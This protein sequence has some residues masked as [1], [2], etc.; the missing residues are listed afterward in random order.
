MCNSFRIK[1]FVWF[2]SNFFF[3]R[4][5]CLKRESYKPREKPIIIFS[6]SSCRKGYLSIAYPCFFYFIEKNKCVSHYFDQYVV[7]LIL[8]EQNK[9]QV[10]Y[11]TGAFYF[12]FRSSVLV[13]IIFVHHDWHISLWFK[14]CYQIMLLQLSFAFFS[15]EDKCYLKC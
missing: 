8:T 5:N 7:G 3:I 6:C 15:L 10:K 13:W 9:L 4:A 11:F 1:Y 12:R 14:I 2:S